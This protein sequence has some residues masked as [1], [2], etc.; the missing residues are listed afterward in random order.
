MQL[1]IVSTLPLCGHGELAVLDKA[2]NVD[3]IVKVFPGGAIVFPMTALHSF[4][5]G[6]I[7]AYV[8]A[9]IELL[10]LPRRACLCCFRLL[11]LGA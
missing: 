5:P 2:S 3:E 4:R 10:Q 1:F 8:S 6:I 9:I 7:T 11:S